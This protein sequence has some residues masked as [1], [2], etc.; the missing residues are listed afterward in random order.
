MDKLMLFT[1][2]S[3]H[4]QSKIGFGAYLAVYENMPI[5]DELKSEVRVK[6]FESTS[7]TKLELQTLLWAISELQ[8]SGRKLIVHTDSQNMM[9]L[10]GRRAR[11]EE[12]GYFSNKGK[13]INHHELYQDFYAMMDQ[14]DYELIK[15]KGHKP[16]DHK[17]EIDR[18]FTM[19]DRAS[20]N[21]LRAII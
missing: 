14:I 9:G 11:F 6:R 18:F 20:R 12:H 5:L 19:V 15:I 4:A 13:L 3:V 7:S 17:D 2:G 1:D 21:A 10:P 16:S 8:I